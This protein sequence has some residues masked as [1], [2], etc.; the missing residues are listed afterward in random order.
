MKGSLVVTGLGKSCSVSGTPAR[1]PDLAGWKA[2]I[3]QTGAATKRKFITFRAE[4]FKFE[5]RSKGGQFEFCPIVMIH[6][7]QAGPYKRLRYASVLP[8]TGDAF[9][10]KPLVTCR[11]S[12]ALILCIFEGP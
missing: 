2:C 9:T 11:K 8:K 12:L 3:S 7:I 10:G 1:N 4:I 5:S 6:K